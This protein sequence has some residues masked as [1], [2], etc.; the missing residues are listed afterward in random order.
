MLTFLDL[1]D[2]LVTLFSLVSLH[3]SWIPSHDVPFAWKYVFYC[4]QIVYKDPGNLSRFT[5]YVIAGSAEKRKEWIDTLRTGDTDWLFTP[6]F[7][8]CLGYSNYITKINTAFKFSLKKHCY[9]LN[10]LRQMFSQLGRD[11]PPR[12]LVKWQLQLLW[13]K[14]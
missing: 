3:I 5:L 8:F 14:R 6:I 12:C 2:D 1:K 9:D 10:S 7:R 11:V 4:Q 13:S